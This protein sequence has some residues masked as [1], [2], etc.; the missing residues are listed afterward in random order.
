MTL[1]EPPIPEKEMC[2]I[3]CTFVSKLR[4]LVTWYELALSQINLSSGGCVQLRFELSWGHGGIGVHWLKS[5]VD[6]GLASV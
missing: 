4:L 3:G 1:T 2:S 6:S 5:L